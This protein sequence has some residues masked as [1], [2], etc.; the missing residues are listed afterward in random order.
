MP[1]R[2]PV[3]ESNSSRGWSLL[4][5]GVKALQITACTIAVVELLRQQWVAAFCFTM[6]WFLIL[7]APRVVPE[8]RKEVRR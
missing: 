5:F 7:R 1:E 4:R 2:S 3:D 6:A 8:L